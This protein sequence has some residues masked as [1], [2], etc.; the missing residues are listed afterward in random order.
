M[1]VNQP[2]KP[3][4]VFGEGD[5][6]VEVL[7]YDKFYRVQL[8]VGGE[9]LYSCLAPLHTDPQRKEG[10]IEQAAHLAHEL[11]FIV[12]YGVFPTPEQRIAAANPVITGLAYAVPQ[13]PTNEYAGEVVGSAF[14]CRYR[15]GLCGPVK[16]C[17]YTFHPLE[18]KHRM[19]VEAVREVGLTEPLP[20]PDSLYTRL[21]KE[22]TL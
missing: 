20:T 22:K 4:F 5:F 10:S 19:R 11:I 1:K 2:K 6:A 15:V 3:D 16:R 9:I 18:T 7:P 13:E 12:K 8:R 21:R 14:I 17:E